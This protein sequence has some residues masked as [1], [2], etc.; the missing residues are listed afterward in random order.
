MVEVPITST[1]NAASEIGVPDVIRADTPG[2]SV[3]PETATALG[4]VII[5]CP[6]T[7]EIKSSGVGAGEP[8]MLVFEVPIIRTPDE[9]QR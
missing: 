6:P 1:P 8:R 4:L 7:V 3:D 5:I 2:M 9:S